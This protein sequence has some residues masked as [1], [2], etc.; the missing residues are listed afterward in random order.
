MDGF[1][2]ML[3]LGWVG[4]CLYEGLAL[5]ARAVLAKIKEEGK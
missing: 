5:I 3:G 2:V 4:M 1:W